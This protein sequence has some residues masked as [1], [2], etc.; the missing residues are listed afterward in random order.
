MRSAH[1][2]LVS[3]MVACACAPSAMVTTSQPVP[4]PGNVIRYATLGDGTQL[5]RASVVS[6]DASRLVAVRDTPVPSGHWTV[7]SVPCDSIAVLQVRI[8][9]QWTLAAVP[10]PVLPPAPAAMTLAPADLILAPFA[11]VPEP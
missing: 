8:G 6:I 10:E 3:A 7:D 1:S 4:Q 9:D 11:R 2:L 5:Q